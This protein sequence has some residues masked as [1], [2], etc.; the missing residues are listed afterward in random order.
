M[1]EVGCVIVVGVWHDFIDMCH[2]VPVEA[3]LL[4]SQNF[5]DIQ[6]CAVVGVPWSLPSGLASSPFS[7]SF[8]TPAT[9]MNKRETL[10]I[11][12]VLYDVICVSP[13]VS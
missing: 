4:V 1:Q 5:L 9:G 13:P 7:F 11:V 2:G 3:D 8:H 6:D 12:D 10:Y